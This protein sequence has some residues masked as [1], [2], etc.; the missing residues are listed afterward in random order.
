[1]SHR[2]LAWIAWA[3]AAGL[4]SGPSDAAVTKPVPATAMERPKRAD[5]ERF[6]AYARSAIELLDRDAKAALL[7]FD[8]V[9]EDPLFSMFNAEQRAITHWMSGIAAWRTGDALDARRRFERATLAHG[10]NP[11][12]WQALAGV[13]QQLGNRERASHHLARVYRRWPVRAQEAE[14]EVVSDLVFNTPEESEPRLELL[15]AL[16]AG[17][18]TH[19]DR[20]PSQVWQNLIQALLT[21]GHVEEARS[22]ARAITDPVVLV[23]LR[24]DRRFDPIADVLSTL[25]SAE[26]AA[27]LEV[28][29]VRSLVARLP[30]RVDLAVDLGAALLVAGRNEDALRASDDALAST[31]AADASTLEYADER[32]WIM[33]NRAVALRRLGRLDEAARQMEEARPLNEHG[34]PNVSQALNLG[35]LYCHLGRPGDARR[36]IGT[37]GPLSPYGQMVERSVRHC[38]AVLE[39]DAAGARAQVAEIYDHRSDGEGVVLDVLMRS[40]DESGAA[41]ELIR[42]LGTSGSRDEAISYVQEFRMAPVLPGTRAARVT[43]A[44]VLQRADVQAAIA[45]VGRVGTHGIHDHAGIE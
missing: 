15:R 30:T 4:T 44:A 12:I 43:R 37:L 26:E 5:V 27:S 1:M 7:A 39:G 6:Q 17:G 18:Y 8:A 41:A 36:V 21:Q 42:Q 33:N 34:Q 29:R 20:G 13:E 32:V 35:M 24:T 10:D 3:L 2:H 28:E 40:G 38:I 23:S 16:F 45:D 25:P 11:D 22:V 9:I 14:L 19:R 31:A